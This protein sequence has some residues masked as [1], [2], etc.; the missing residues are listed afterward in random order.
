MR[1]FPLALPHPHKPL[2]Q[3][4][5][6]T[7]LQNA[8][9]EHHAFNTRHSKFSGD[10]MQ[11]RILWPRAFNGSGLN[12]SEVGDETVCKPPP[13]HINIIVR[14]SL[15]WWPKFQRQSGSSAEPVTRKPSHQRKYPGPGGRAKVSIQTDVEQSESQ[16][17]ARP[18][19]CESYDFVGW[20]FGHTKHITPGHGNFLLLILRSS[21]FRNRLAL[22]FST[23]N[24]KMSWM[25]E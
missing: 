14:E 7:R 11:T 20:L 13:R 23:S 24:A 3:T 1:S 25:E 10:W 22:T 12:V 17:P 19:L 4:I 9:C 15:R 2:Y 18:W 21:S 5:S 6:T 16:P 8:F